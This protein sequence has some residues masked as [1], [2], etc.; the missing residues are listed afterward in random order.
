MEHICQD[1]YSQ[2]RYGYSLKRLCDFTAAINGTMTVVSWRLFY[3]NYA[4]EHHGVIFQKNY[5]H[6]K[7]PIIV[8]IDGRQKDCGRIFF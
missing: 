1:K 8:S 6:G 2:M 3:G 5:A 7:Q 4:Q